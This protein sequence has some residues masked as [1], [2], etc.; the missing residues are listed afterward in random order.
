[1][2]DGFD[3]SLES[4]SR[5]AATNNDSYWQNIARN[6]QQ[7]MVRNAIVP[8]APWLPS[9]AAIESARAYSPTT[10]SENFRP[11]DSQARPDSAQNPLGMLQAAEAS[12]AQNGMTADTK[13]LY[14]NAIAAADASY[15]T[16]NATVLKTLTD[17][18]TTGKKMD[19]SDVTPDERFRGHQIL[20]QT[21][22][23]AQL[24]VQFR[25]LYAATLLQTR[26]FATCEATL[27]DAIN[28]S[29]RMPQNVVKPAQE[30]L[31]RDLSNPS[32]SREQQLMLEE[33]QKDYVGEKTFQR[34]G[35]GY[36][37]AL[38]RI[39]AASFYVSAQPRDEDKKQNGVL[40]P[41][42]ALSML[43][44]AK[45]VYQQNLH[46]DVSVKG[47]DPLFDAV[48]ATAK[49]MLPENLK[50]EKASADGFWSDNLLDFAVGAAAFGV[51]AVTKVNPS[52][53]S[54]AG[55]VLM[56]GTMV[57]GATVARHYG[58]ELLTGDS[59]T[60]LN[61]TI[62]G[63]ASVAEIG[64]IA[65]VKGKL[66]DVFFKGATADAALLRVAEVRGT[67]G[68]LTS[69]A[70]K[71]LYTANKLA[72]P[73]SLSA[74]DSTALLVKDGTIVNSVDLG[75]NAAKSAEL[76]RLALSSPSSNVLIQG[77]KSIITTPLNVARG[78]PA[79]VNPTELNLATATAGQIGARSTLTGF[80]SALAGAE[81]YQ[82]ITAL[83]RAYN[84]N[85][86][87]LI[88]YGDSFKN[89]MLSF[90]PLVGALFIA[91]YLKP[92]IMPVNYY[93]EGAGRVRNAWSSVRNMFSH[94]G[95]SGHFAQSESAMSRAAASTV[96]M[97]A[98]NLVM[99]DSVWNR[100]AIVHDSKDL[101][102]QQTGH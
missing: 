88:S 20:D 56:A 51:A 59:E 25:F 23:N 82:A 95:P 100:D 90:E 46:V 52:M 72:I 83:D 67:E 35:F 30:L 3:N 92:G 85:T 69:G 97:A 63:A 21:L 68:A 8:A 40:K 15:D 66:T 81:G 33:L 22:K 16:Q 86:G 13:K 24:G 73:K 76:T 78:I 55:K 11:Q 31:Q 10:P 96:P 6:A 101:L 9:Y 39:E 34:P 36:L 75:L 49:R 18:L 79:I 54:A 19:G 5:Q 17:V 26:Q 4:S 98:G 47:T 80:A 61:S 58:H 29:D 57:S 45:A 60:W 93:S 77:A 27:K 99:W 64:I 38:T 48:S 84:A 12:L 32:L 14:Q 102:E 53:L 74:I 70:L 7:S 28:A 42:R 87:E 94:L 62:H 2:G 44:S 50:K 37:P 1:M 41:E 43:D 71:E 89:K 91:P 65:G